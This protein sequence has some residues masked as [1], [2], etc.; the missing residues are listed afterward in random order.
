MRQIKA[1]ID[2][3]DEAEEQHIHETTL[4]LLWEIG[5]Q[6]QEKRVL[7]L[8]ASAGSEVDFERQVVKIPESLIDQALAFIHQKI[9]PAPEAGAISALGLT[10]TP[11]PFI[12]DYPGK[13]RRYGTMEDLIKGIVI[14]NQMRHLNYANPIV[15]PQDVTPA[16]S[17]LVSYQA[18]YTYAK[19]PGDAYI[20]SEWSAGYIIELASVLQRQTA[21][22]VEPV[23][24]LRFTE[25]HLRLAVLF[26]EKGQRL[27]TGPM[28]I[29]GLSG[30][31]TL[32]GTLVIQNAEILASLV[33]VYL[34]GAPCVY[35]YSGGAHT[36]DMRTSLCSFGSP[37]QVLLVL[38]ERQLARRYGLPCLGSLGLTDALTSD[39]QMGFEKGLSAGISSL[40][41]VQWI[42]NQG[43]IG[44]DQ[45]A[46][47]EQ[48][49]IDD[50]WADALNYILR[51]FEV[52]EETLAWESIRSVSIGGSFIAEDHTARHARDNY[53]KS[54]L[55][56][57]LPWDS[58]STLEL[59]TVYDRANEKVT[60]I[61]S[62]NYPP[63]PLIEEAERKALE[64][65]VLLAKDAL[66]E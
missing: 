22:L 29:A 53:W 58:S 27:A 46:S 1:V 19:K 61:L 36:M 47:L 24:P 18:M 44:A 66:G 20:N 9:E 4:H 11:Q 10:M 39:F 17:D 28:V 48:M 30:P 63:E 5:V 55:F 40:A 42:G 16:L 62:K 59:K 38:A 54:D 2:V 6:M 15:T 60:K 32:A 35:R 7:K 26:A 51:G 12:V 31:V 3:L 65:I 45:A 14:A 23:S 37:N 43:H 33:L 49:M 56:S 13:H 52:T 41:G 25:E 34:L 8:F 57:R 21:Y 50:E 64:K